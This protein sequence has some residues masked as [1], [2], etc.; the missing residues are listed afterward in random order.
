MIF[1]P[2]EYRFPEHSHAV[3]FG[4]NWSLNFIPLKKKAYDSI[5]AIRRKVSFAWL[6]K[7]LRDPSSIKSERE[8]GLDTWG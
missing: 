4:K 1:L 5:D 8:K 6:S 3:L 7:V 2:L